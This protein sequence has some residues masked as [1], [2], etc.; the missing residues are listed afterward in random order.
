MGLDITVSTGDYDVE[1]IYLNGAYRNIARYLGVEDVL[2]PREV[3]K[4][5]V[6]AKEL[7]LPLGR[8]I[9]V[10]SSRF[11]EFELLCVSD[12]TDGTVLLSAIC[13]LLAACF[14]YPDAVVSFYY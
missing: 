12:H 9:W 5:S 11:D 4:M 6:Q 7:V 13:D 1:S 8:A 2:W 10:A 3:P 14:D